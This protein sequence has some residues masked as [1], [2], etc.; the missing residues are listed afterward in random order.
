MAGPLSGVR[1]IDAT[2][3]LSGPWATMML[4][5]QGADV[6][7][8][9]APGKGDHVRSLGNAR[10]GMSAMF[11]NINRNKR[12]LA[13]DLKSPRGVQAVK[14]LALGAD[15]FVQNFRPGVVDRLGIG[16]P[17]L[18]ALNPNLIYVSIAGFGEKGPWSGKPVYDPIIQAVSGLTTVQAGAD[19]ERPRLVRTVLPDKVSAIVAA[20]AISS[21][22]FARE[23]NGGG[24][25]VR[26]AMLD[27]VLYFLWASDMGGQT[28]PDTEVKS[29]EAASFIDLIY[30]TA[31]GY[32][33][34]AVMSD[35]EWAGVTRAL[36]RPDWLADPRFATPAARDRHV[37]ER[38]EMTQAV[39]K[40]R[41]TAEWMALFE[42]N[43]VP[44]APALTR[45]EVITHPQV[46]A[47]EIIIEH[48]HHAA[49]PLRQTRA[50]ARFEGTPTEIRRGAPLLGEHSVEILRE[51][52]WET[53]LISELMGQKI[54]QAP[55]AAQNADKEHV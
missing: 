50:P 42:A 23:R 14:E 28:Y 10:G 16:E 52:G 49:G 45:R 33:T 22:L 11:L 40:T 34:V 4:A 12:S 54:V 32:M 27:A 41:T 39:L 30:E 51:L 53:G 25:H 17:V 43:D 20:Q 29:Q 7:K 48:A 24:Q 5:D 35:R 2:T 3:M 6:I 9:E 19:S 38:L 1:I 8:I 36:E 37:N 46:L 31:D 15:V 47:N 13:I 44:C 55:R 26:L 21:A 18:R